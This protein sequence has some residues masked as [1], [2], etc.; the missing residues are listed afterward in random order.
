MK[1]VIC[2]VVVILTLFLCYLMVINKHYGDYQFYIQDK[3]VNIAQI[4]IS[5]PF[6]WGPEGGDWDLEAIFFTSSAKLSCKKL[7]DVGDLNYYIEQLSKDD[8]FGVYWFDLDDR[9]YLDTS[10]YV[11]MEFNTQDLGGRWAFGDD[12]PWE[13]PLVSVSK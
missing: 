9:I 2:S 1:Y 3:G 11:Q 4:D 5:I 8:S 7:E 10:Y 6:I 12:S 13:G